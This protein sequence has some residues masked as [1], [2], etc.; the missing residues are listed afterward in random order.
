MLHND[1]SSINFT[2]NNL[3]ELISNRIV[4]CF[5]NIYI[6]PRQS[7]CLN[8]RKPI[9]LPDTLIGLI[10]EEVK[11]I[12]QFFSISDILLCQLIFWL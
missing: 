11:V 10:G 5:W 4:V 2:M 9:I 7:L 3:F 12:P 1:E 8:I 6:L